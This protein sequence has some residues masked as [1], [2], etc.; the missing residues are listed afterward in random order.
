MDTYGLILAG[1]GL[2]V[3]VG[4]FAIIILEGDQFI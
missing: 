4:L 1:Y 2:I 3:L